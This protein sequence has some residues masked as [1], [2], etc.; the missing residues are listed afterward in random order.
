MFSIEVM[1]SINTVSTSYLHLGDVR[2]LSE[3]K[4]DNYTKTNF[5]GFIKSMNL[6]RG[7][8]RE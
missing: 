3:E 4:T 8:Q 7:E 2:K 1:P 6:R 5:K